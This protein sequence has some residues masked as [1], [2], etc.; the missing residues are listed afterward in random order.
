MIALEL[1]EKSLKEE[2]IWSRTNKI[3]EKSTKSHE[4][5]KILGHVDQLK[6]TS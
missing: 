5:F 2:H 4:T 6:L 3:F 1:A